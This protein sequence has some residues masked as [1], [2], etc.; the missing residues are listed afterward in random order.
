MVDSW[1]GYT[2]CAD[3]D[4]SPTYKS[5]CDGDGHTEALKLEYDPSVTSFE[6]IIR[7]YY[8]DPHVP[9]QFCSDDSGGGRSATDAVQYR[10]AIWA[11]DD[12]QREIAL[13]VSEE[14]GKQI[15]VLQPCAWHDAEGYHQHYCDPLARRNE[16]K[17]PPREAPR[18]WV[19]FSDPWTT[20]GSLDAE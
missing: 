14:V 4:A 8:E 12:S 15:P 18:P 5:V 10:T 9:D 2:G 16:W 19:S 3:A 7:H 6:E 1:V 11:Q 13:R 17:M 20:H